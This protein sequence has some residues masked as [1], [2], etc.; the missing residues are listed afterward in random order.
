[1]RR[2]VVGLFV[3]L[4]ASSPAAS[5]ARA[6]AT[7]AAPTVSLHASTAIVDFGGEVKLS[8]AVDPA[9]K[10]QTIELRDAAG[11]LLTTLST[12]S[13]GRFAT[14]MK[15]R[16]NAELHA[17]WIE[18]GVDSAAVG[19]RVR[20]V[21]RVGLTDVRLFGSALARGSVRPARAGGRI[22]VELLRGG[23]VALV[24]R[25]AMGAAGGFRTRLPIE[26]VGSYRVRAT[27]DPTDLAPGR[28]MSSTGTTPLPPL[29]DG[30][31]GPFVRLLEGRL[32]DLDYHLVGIDQRYDARTGDAVLAFQ[33]IQGMPRK[34]NVTEAVWRAL[35]DPKRPRPRSTAR[36]LHIEV[37]LRSQV[38]F[39]V[40]DGKVHAILH[41]STGKPST[42]TNPGMFQVYRKFAGYSGNQLYYPSYFDGLRAIHGWPDVPTYPASHGCVRAPMWAAKWIYGLAS[43]GTKV[44]VHS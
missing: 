4:L 28:A 25:V 31:R 42:P 34:A 12:G 27:F 6:S 44:L 8:G 14:A 5:W 19:V 20:P 1:M 2:G 22:R 23:H 17:T 38:L 11:A 37:D 43:I 35:A 40:E 29:L 32:A 33:K 16:A 39:T 3:V 26:R 9:T 30:S 18:Q 7:R 15:P 13:R 41:V 10:G 24:R 36:G 21:V